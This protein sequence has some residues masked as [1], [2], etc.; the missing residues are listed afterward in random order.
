MYVK[1]KTHRG[2]ENTKNRSHGKCTNRTDRRSCCLSHDLISPTRKSGSLIL[3]KNHRTT[4]KARH[5]STLYRVTIVHLAHLLLSDSCSETLLYQ[6]IMALCM[7]LQCG[8]LFGNFSD[9]FVILQTS[10]DPQSSFFF[11]S[12]LSICHHLWFSLASSIFNRSFNEYTGPICVCRLLYD[13]ADFVMIS[14][15]PSLLALLFWDLENLFIALQITLW[16]PDID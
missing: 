4:R 2:K 7:I 8:S 9:L 14:L 6:K 5:I 12:Q 13:F 3:K 10:S 1:P 15:T 16:P 11:C